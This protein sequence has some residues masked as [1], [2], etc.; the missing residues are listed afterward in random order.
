MDTKKTGHLLKGD[1]SQGVIFKYF[2]VNRKDT[3]EKVKAVR[4]MR[5]V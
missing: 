5:E 1:V 4:K 2:P 3:V